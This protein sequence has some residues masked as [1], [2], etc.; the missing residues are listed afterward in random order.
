MEIT[1]GMKV[2]V[3]SQIFD[4]QIPKNQLLHFRP[5]YYHRK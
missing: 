3:S 1:Q 4:L 2:N 5:L